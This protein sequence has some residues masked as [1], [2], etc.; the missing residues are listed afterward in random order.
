MDCNYGNISGTV[1]MF[2]IR[3]VQRKRNCAD[4][5]ERWMNLDYAATEQFISFLGQHLT[6]NIHVK[7]KQSFPLLLI[8][9]FKISPGKIIA[10]VI[11]RKF[12]DV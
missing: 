4:R 10:N 6:K 8:K 7:I 1:M 2:K 5:Y 3:N 11:T 9:K 12:I